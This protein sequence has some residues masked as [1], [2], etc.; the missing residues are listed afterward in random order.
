[1][2][3]EKKKILLIAGVVVLIV[4]AA[5]VAVLLFNINS[6]KHRIETAASQATG[7]DVRINGKM[8]LSFF[9]FSVS[10][11]DI[12]VTNNGGVI[13]I[14]KK[15]KIG[16]EIIPLFAKQFKVT[17]CQLVK[18][19]ISIVK[20][21]EGKYNFKSTEKKS[22]EG[23]PTK[24]ISLKELR[25]SQGTLVYLDE[26]T[27]EKTELK[28]ISL[29]I[30]DL[31]IDSAAGDNIITKVSFTGNLGC[32]EVWKKDLKIDNVETSLKAE[33]GVIYL[34]HLTMDI[35]G[36]K[37]EGDATLDMS[38]VDT[39]YKVNLKVLTLDFAKLQESF[40]IK[41]VIG[42]KS[43]LSASLTMNQKRSRVLINSINGTFSLRG[44]N[45][46]IY[47]MD[48]DKVPYRINRARS[49]T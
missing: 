41:K 18:P 13:L 48:L 38:G 11:S 34:T 17:S 37:G 9:P 16:V 49:S 29:A 7:L 45:L 35:F 21:N 40:G 20:D 14:L 19:T 1:M 26:K 31:S 10:A 28:E 43:D 42:G 39:V 5:I 22:A 23:G 47:T 12:R 44:D 2:V 4:I 33:N 8:G 6:Y 27:G 3:A 30:K 15:L 24:A 46:V 25:L 32:K 36:G